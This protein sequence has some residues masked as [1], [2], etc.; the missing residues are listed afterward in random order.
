MPLNIHFT[1]FFSGIPVENKSVGGYRIKSSIEPSNE[2]CNGLNG[3][4]LNFLFLIHTSPGNRIHL[5]LKYYFSYE[6]L[7]IQ[8]YFCTFVLIIKFPKTNFLLHMVLKI[9]APFPNKFLSTMKIGVLSEGITY[10]KN[11]NIF[12]ACKLLMIRNFQRN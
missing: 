2:I 8:L 11:F 5:N 1:F 6:R 4:R 10:F 3:K 9:N 12:L 7:S